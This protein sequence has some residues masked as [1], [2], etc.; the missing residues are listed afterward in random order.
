MAT[1]DAMLGGL[2]LLAASW[3]RHGAGADILAVDVGGATTDVHTHVRAAAAAGPQHAGLEPEEQSSRTVEG[4]L[5]IRWSAD[6][7]IDAA[8][9]DGGAGAAVA[10]ELR[11]AARMRSR[12]V[13]FV[14]RDASDAQQDLALAA[15]AAQMAVNRHAGTLKFGIDA[16]GSA[17]RTRGKDLRDVRVVIAAGGVFRHAAAGRV[18]E[19]LAGA[20]C[21]VGSRRRLLPKRPATF[22]VDHRH[23]LTVAGVLSVAEPRLAR[24]VVERAFPPPTLSG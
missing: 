3:A 20:C 9:S 10:D 13:A 18:T 4:D 17:V 14:G 23:A 2:E 21:P 24:R 5:G 15:L 19:V 8:I 16:G 6:S 22:L 1:P 7:L 11:A 12:D